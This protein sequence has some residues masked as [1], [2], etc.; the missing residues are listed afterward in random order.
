MPAHMRFELDLGRPTVRQPIPRDADRPLRLLVIGNFS[1][2][3]AT[4]RP[5]LGERPTHRVDV[6]NLDAVLERLAP[7]LERATGEVRFGSLDDFHPDALYERLDLF[8]A[9]REA[10]LRPPQSAGEL[11]GGLLGAPPGA[12]G[13]GAP[14]PVRT[15]ID[16]LVHAIVAPHVVKDDAAQRASYVA[17]V[18]A[19]IAEQMRTLLH[20]PAF[21]SLEAAW[22]GVAWLVRNLELGDE[23]QLHLFDAGRD[24]L[25]ADLVAA[26][27]RLAETGLHHAL[28]D[29]WRQVP[30]DAGWSLLAGLYAFGPGDTDIGLLAALG[31][32]ASQA[33]G[34]FVAA[35]EPAL[36]AADA[37]LPEGWQALRR[38]AA[39]P[40]IGLA[41]PRLLLRLPYGKGVDPITAFAFEEFAGAPEHEAFLWGSPALA[42]ALLIG[43]AFAARGWD[44][45]PGDE[46]EID[47]LPA[48]SYMKD[49]ER[50]LQAC[51]ERYLGEQAG[52]A[53]LDAGLMPLLSHRDCNAVTV[54]RFQSVAQ[55][56]QAL[57]RPLAA[58]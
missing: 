39:A 6:D 12:A 48:Y 52:Q 30:G 17:A 5:P 28:A 36:A 44:F 22:R 7:R 29:R 42:V 26:Q 53:M 23:L 24:E 18:D 37:G 3:P 31:L 50:E 35:A 56:A 45:E 25:L 41:A 27:G 58:G 10:R 57:A 16:A 55:P 9:L 34:P 4:P 14:A 47:D 21:Q 49:G 54:P 20:D 8:A 2:T 32:V 51:A 38:T 46:R 19:A 40:W 13:S 33:G 15:G 43:R 1:G 11:L